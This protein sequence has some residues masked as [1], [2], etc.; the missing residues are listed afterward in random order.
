MLVLL[1]LALGSV[2]HTQSRDVIVHVPAHQQLLAERFHQ[3]GTR[4]LTFLESWLGPLPAGDVVIEAVP[5]RAT[6]V[7]A[8]GRTLRVPQRWWIL[9]GDRTPERFIVAGLAR[10]YWFE[11]VSF[12]D[13]EQWLA[14]GLVRFTAVRAAAE[15]VESEHFATP[16]FFGDLFAFPVRSAPLTSDW[17]EARPPVPT[18]D[19]VEDVL[20][21]TPQARQARSRRAGRAL[22]MLERYLGRP[23]LDG[24]IAEFARRSRG[25]VVSA[26]DLTTTIEEVTGRDLAWFFE[27]AFDGDARYD[28]GLGNVE[29]AASTDGHH[30]KITI[31][32]F[33]NAV[34]SGSSLSPI[35]AFEEGRAI[36]ILAGFAD[37][38][39]LRTYW[40]GRAETR[41]VDFVSE[42]PLVA[43]TV[44]PAAVLLL[45]DDWAN[46]RWTLTPPARAAAVQWSLLWMAWLQHAMLSLT[47]IV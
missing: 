10:R 26:R 11:L 16:R 29:T 32:R 35:G 8:E 37:G 34:F 25:R 12:S 5:W 39:Q 40:D 14:G 47:A 42:A 17:W 36:E 4:A 1:L 33:G 19:E 28:Y 30:S 31:R 2:G 43:V 46:N 20:A 18:F 27:T 23:V 41:V 38:A 21:A 7:P 15:V 9:P 44:D 45:D 3:S 24:A 22:Q 13:Q 6:A